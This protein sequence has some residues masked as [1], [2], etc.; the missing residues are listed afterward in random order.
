M[1]SNA[2]PASHVT[3]LLFRHAVPRISAE[4]LP[5]HYDPSKSL[6]V[7]ATE[8]GFLPLVEVCA[9]AQMETATST[10]V[11]QEGDDDDFASTRLL[12][13]MLLD[14]STVTKVRQE[15]DD[16]DLSAEDTLGAVRHAGSI[17]DL[18]TK[19]A[20]QQESDDEISASALLELETRTLNNQEGFDE[21]WPPRGLALQVETGSSTG[22]GNG[23]SL[24]H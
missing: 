14:T 4:A 15:G 5:G 17:A 1:Q 24:G 11:R 3:P 6:W 20:V 2:N 22:N 18:V 19:T 12:A 9:P 13:G 23:R 16:D 7:I 8:T 10:R 21:D